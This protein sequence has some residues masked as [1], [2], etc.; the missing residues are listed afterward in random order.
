MTDPADTRP[1]DLLRAVDI[2]KRSGLRFV[3]AGNLA[4][5][6][7]DLEDTKCSNCHSILVKR[8]S[9][10]VEQYRVTAEGACPD[11]GI[12]IPGRWAKEFDGQIA[13]VPF[14]PRRRSRLFTIN[15]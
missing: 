3:Y 1:E 11:C 12:Q 7:G 4:G 5:M 2:G 8:Y 14:L 9:Y 10:L 15:R 6:V 13:S